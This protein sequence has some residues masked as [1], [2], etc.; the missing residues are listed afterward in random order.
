MSFEEN[1]ESIL[2]QLEVPAEVYT[3]QSPKGSVDVAIQD[4]ISEINAI[5]GLVTT[6]SCSGRVAVYLEGQNNRGSARSGGKGGGKWLFVTHDPL[7]CSESHSPVSLLFGQDV[8][9]GAVPS[10]GARFVHF[11]FEPMVES[12]SPDVASILATD[13]LQILHILTASLPDAQRVLAAALQ[14]GFRESGAINLVE[15]GNKPVTPMVAV[16][17][18]GLAVDSIIGYADDGEQLFSL[19]T[20]SYLQSLI[21]IAN[22]RFLSNSERIDRFRQLLRAKYDKL[23]SD[24]RELARKK[25]RKLQLKL[26]QGV[27][28]EKKSQEEL[29]RNEAATYDALE[30]DY[31]ITESDAT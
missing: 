10:K 11:K 17:T 7:T 3:D 15:A 19:V 30:L 20:D 1:K 28:K 4:L 25:A 26:A 18:N 23:E 5:P 31:L 9:D 16:R 14:A 2:K 12:S 27:A 13:E 24:E 6:S 21:H 29:S 22:E 8:E